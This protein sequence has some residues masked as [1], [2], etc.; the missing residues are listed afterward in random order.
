[1]GVDVTLNE[2]RIYVRDLTGIHSTDLVST[3]LL[4]RWINES[5]NELARAQK[6]PWVSSM[7]ELSAESH[8]PVFDAQFH[9]LL[10]YR[11]ASKVL[12]IQADDTSRA[13]LY[14]QEYTTLY[15]AMVQF[16]FAAAAVSSASTRAQ[17]RRFVRDLTSVNSERVTDATIDGFLNEAYIELAQAKDWEWLEGTD[18]VTLAAGQSNF[19]VSSARRILELFV[20]RHGEASAVRSVPHLLDVSERSS[21]LRYDINSAGT[22]TLAP[23][24][25]TSIDLR[26]RFI[27]RTVALADDSDIPVFGSAFHKILGYRA[28]LSVAGLMGAPDAFAGFLQSQYRS[29]F[30]AMVSNYQL[31]HSN[32]PLQMGGASSTVWLRA[33]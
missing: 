6:W 16:Y 32:E 31:E 19:T 13:E 7:T 20:I 17:L 24:P 8:T 21:T 10:A 18:E 1:M 26:Y 33:E 2:L 4:T 23:T 30:E 5:Y 25:T 15:E 29:L 28:A 9:S 11:V 27:T 14:G 22:V 12:G 3:D